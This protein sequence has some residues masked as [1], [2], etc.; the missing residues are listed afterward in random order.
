MRLIVNGESWV[1][2]FWHENHV[3]N[4]LRPHYI[5]RG[6]QAGFHRG[7]C[8]LATSGLKDCAIK[9]TDVAVFVFPT[10]VIRRRAAFVHGHPVVLKERWSM[11]F[12]RAVGRR[13]ALT[14]L[15]FTMFPTRGPG[16]DKT[17]RAAFWEAY[18]LALKPVAGAR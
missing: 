11:P 8:V 2:H 10:N 16:D 5:T 7:D 17:I 6:T 12:S 18:W 3:P 15:L 14:R 1:L 4:D 9:T 13:E